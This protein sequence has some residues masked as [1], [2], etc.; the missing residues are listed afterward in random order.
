MYGAQ[1]TYGA[2]DAF[3]SYAAGVCVLRRGDNL[4]AAVNLNLP[5]PSELAL[6][7]QWVVTNQYRESQKPRRT[8][9]DYHSAVFQECKVRFK[10][11]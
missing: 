2:L 5:S 9:H 1:V 10:A 8:K 3:V 11:A 6:A 7:T 4:P